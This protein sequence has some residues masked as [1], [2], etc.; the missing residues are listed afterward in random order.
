VENIVLFGGGTHV[1]YC[2]DIIEK[3]NKYKIVGITD[4]FAE[5]DSEILGYKIIG[6]QE[7]IKKLVIEYDI[8]AGLVTIGDNWTRKIVRDTILNIIPDFKFV[9][10][11]HPSTIIGR[12][13]LIREGT[14]I[15]AGCIINPGAKIYEFCFL[16][17][18]A[19]LEHDSLMEEFS[20]LSAG[21]VTGGKVKIGRFTAITL[22]VILF[23]RIEIGEHTVIGSGSLVTKNIPNN[24]LAY[25]TPAKVIR[26]RQIGEK[27]LAS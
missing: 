3:E 11:I 24:V 27:Y 16:A 9:S 1:R 15:M 8:N 4:P 25:G 14:V 7:E 2:I 20:S 21:S 6:R 18:G 23:D 13:V 19:I 5:I 12:N 17:T 22:G 26:S 10:A